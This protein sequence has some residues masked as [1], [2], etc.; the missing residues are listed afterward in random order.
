[1]D[2]CCPGAETCPRRLT[3][4]ALLS[5]GVRPGE[6]R[7]GTLAVRPPVVSPPASGR[8][9]GDYFSSTVTFSIFPVNL[10]G[11]LQVLVA[12]KPTSASRM[13]RTLGE[14]LGALTGCGKSGTDS[15]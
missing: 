7:T 14:P 15:L 10:N 11:S 3:R 4:R 2:A 9:N 8:A 13:S 12:P 5:T 1:G 6:G